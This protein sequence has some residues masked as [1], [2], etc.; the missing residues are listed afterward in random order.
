MSTARAP[1]RLLMS[2]LFDHYRQP[3]QTVHL[4]FIFLIDGTLLLY[5]CSQM[6]VRVKGEVDKKKRAG[7]LIRASL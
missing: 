1:G 7:Q 3:S 4:F 2:S 5:A 6:C